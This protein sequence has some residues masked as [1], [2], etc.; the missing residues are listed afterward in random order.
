MMTLETITVL[1]AALS[2]AMPGGEPLAPAPVDP[3]NGAGARYARMF[4]LSP[5]DTDATLL[6]EIG[7]PGGLSDAGETEAE[8]LIAAGWPFFGQYVA[9]D[10]TADRSPLDAAYTGLA[11][12]RNAR[13]PRANLE[14]LYGDGP[15]RRATC[16]NG[17]TRR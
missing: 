8:A 12:L 2:P 3:R 5:L 15:V 11:A 6:H 9:H 14:L 17:T 16:S 1:P 4:D 13:S 7:A 10:L